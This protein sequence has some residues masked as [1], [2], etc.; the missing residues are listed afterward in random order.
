[1]FFIWLE[2]K[3]SVACKIAWPDAGRGKF[4][5]LRTIATA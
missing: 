5:W 3:V 4:G 1:V 2:R